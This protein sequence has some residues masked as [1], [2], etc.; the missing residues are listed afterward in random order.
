[1]KREQYSADTLY[2]FIFPFHP[3]YFSGFM[4]VQALPCDHFHYSVLVMYDI[5]DIREPEPQNQS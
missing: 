2:S 5:F 4:I 3:T 1:M